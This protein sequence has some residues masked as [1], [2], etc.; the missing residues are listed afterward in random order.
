LRRVWGAPRLPRCPFLGANRDMSRQTNRRLAA[1]SQEIAGLQAELAILREQ[2]AF[3][4]DVRDEAHLRALVA[5]TPL[6][7][8][9]YRVASE[10]FSR[11]ERGVAEAERRVE[12][13]RTEQD[14]L[15]AALSQAGPP[16]AE[17]S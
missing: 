11:I 16:V 17:R 8:R 2:L 7:D 14:R 13:L 3:Q 9:E 15:L 6:A 12:S 4:R 5:E 10:D 1:I